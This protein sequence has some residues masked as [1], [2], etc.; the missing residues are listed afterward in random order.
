MARGGSRLANGLGDGKGCWYSR[1]WA[2]LPSRPVAVVVTTRASVADPAQT[3]EGSVVVR[4]EPFDGSRI[5]T[6]MRR[7]ATAP[8]KGCCASRPTAGKMQVTGRTTTPARSASR[9][10]TREPVNS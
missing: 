10:P 1:Q 6:W 5:E 9:R 7:F 8:P 4:L 2:S 3:A